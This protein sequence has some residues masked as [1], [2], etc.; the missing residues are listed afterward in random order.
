MV[1]SIWSI[2]RFK[3]GR[4]VVRIVFVTSFFVLSVFAFSQEI[5]AAENQPNDELSILYGEYKN[6]RQKNSQF[7]NS[8]EQKWAVSLLAC[9]KKNPDS[10]AISKVC[11]QLI[12]MYNTL[13]DWYRTIH[14]TEYELAKSHPSL[15]KTF[16]N[17]Q[18]LEACSS[19]AFMEHTQGN[20]D[21]AQKNA[22]KAID[23]MKNYWKAASKE[24][25]NIITGIQLSY[26]ILLLQNMI[27]NLPQDAIATSQQI[28]EKFS[29]LKNKEDC[30]DEELLHGYTLDVFYIEKIKAEIEAGEN[31][32][33]FK[34]IEQYGELPEFPH[35]SYVGASYFVC[36][37]IAKIYPDR[38]KDYCQFLTSW[39]N[40]HNQ[41]RMNCPAL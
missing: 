24:E 21:K 29:Q 22:T 4:L 6:Y 14:I 9:Y 7:D 26:K 41:C 10:P 19:A 31:E 2:R 30:F 34:T 17:E 36:E 38:N 40:N 12:A 5:A 23:V 18:L 1:N 33:A 3:E 8:H 20:L 37:A 15:D 39:I 13:G 32:A 25:K 27:L 16:L 28:I 11:L 35:A